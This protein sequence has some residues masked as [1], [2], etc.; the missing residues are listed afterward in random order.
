MRE[1]KMNRPTHFVNFYYI[2]PLA[3]LLQRPSGQTF[4]R[5]LYKFFLKTVLAMEFLTTMKW[6][7]IFSPTCLELMN[8]DTLSA[9]V[10]RS[11]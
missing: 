1:R 6:F 3:N 2:N 9:V 5:K 4:R 8:T 11:S 7:Y 10:A